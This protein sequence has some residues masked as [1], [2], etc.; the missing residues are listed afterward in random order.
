[1]G[2][3]KLLEKSVRLGLA[4]LVVG[5][6]AAVGLV[7]VVLYCAQPA[8]ATFP[9]K[10]G[11]IAYVTP[12][13]P[14]S[15]GDIYTINPDGRS[16]VQVTNTKNT[17]EQTPDYSPDA[18]KI[19]YTDY[20]QGAPGGG[21]YTTSV[22][23]GGKSRVTGGADPSYSPNGKRIAYV[24][25]DGHDQ[26]IYTI[27]VGGGG[28]VQVTNNNTDDYNPSYSPNGK[29]IAYEGWNRN[30]DSD[31]YTIKATGGK[32]FNLTNSGGFDEGGPTYSPNGK[33]IAYSRG[34]IG[35][36]LGKPNSYEIYTITATGGTPFQ[37]THNKMGDWEPSYSPDGK[38]IAYARG[39]RKTD[40]EIYTINAGGGGRVQVTHNRTD[41]YDPSWGSRL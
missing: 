2:G 18:K 37:L 24:A 3:T 9:G 14:R 13:G 28:K 6:L 7:A 1:M 41:D 12:T 8:E 34:V 38:K 16:K 22:R 32:P 11:K 23:G 30:Y 19:A 21:I 35:N 20:R 40:D 5:M 25:F 39:G 4:S 17:W 10:N 31:I 27:N 36:G 29:K 26:E 33:K 15:L